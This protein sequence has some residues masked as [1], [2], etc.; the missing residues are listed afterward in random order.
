MRKL[1][2]VELSLPWLPPAAAEGGDETELSRLAQAHSADV[3]AKLAALLSLPDAR[4]RLSGSLEALKL[5]PSSAAVA[6]PQL[7]AGFRR[8]SVIAL[9]DCGTGAPL[10]AVPPSFFPGSLQTIWAIKLAT[11]R[12]LRWL[13]QHRLSL[14]DIT[15][16]GMVLQ[17]PPAALAAGQL[18]LMVAGDSFVSIGT[19]AGCDCQCIAIVAAGGMLALQPVAAS[20]EDWDQRAQRAVASYPFA[21][22]ASP[23]QRQLVAWALALQ[24]LFEAHSRLQKVQVGGGSLLLGFPPGAAGEALPDGGE[25]RAWGQA[26]LTP[27]EEPPPPEQASVSLGG[28]AVYLWPPAH[29]GLPADGAAL[30]HLVAERL[31]ARCLQLA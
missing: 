21:A 5:L 26:A 9:G 31:P 19:L 14:A 23:L 25:I 20:F 18:I 17:G 6:H 1:G 10:E 30:V 3:T 13:P 4:L 7:L 22:T 11:L 15:P 24:P 27:P 28:I 29:R 2:V 12:S 8:L 16:V